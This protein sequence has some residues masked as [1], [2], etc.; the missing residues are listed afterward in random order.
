MRRTTCPV[1]LA[2]WLGLVASA[3]A[4]DADQSE[5]IMLPPVDEPA[6]SEP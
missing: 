5:L 6:A 4:A 1:A 2:A 3:A